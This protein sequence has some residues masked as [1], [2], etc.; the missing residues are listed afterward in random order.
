MNPSSTPSIGCAIITHCAKHHLSHC[1]PPLLNSSLKPRVVVV[2][3][4][5]ND[6]TVELAQSMGAET[7]LI[8]RHEFN[9]GIT[10]ERARQYL[11]TDIV[12]MLTPD[13]YLVDK[14]SLEKLITPIANGYA[15]AAYARQLPHIGADFFEAF[16]REYNYPNHSHIRSIENVDRYGVYTFFCSNSCAAYSNRIMDE[17]GGFQRVLLGED[18][19]AIA[20]MLRKGYKI[21]YVAEAQ[22]RHSHRYTLLEEFRRSFDT[23]LARKSYA[24]VLAC[25]SSDSKRGWDYAQVMAKRL[26]K[27]APQKLPYAIGQVFAKWM[28]YQLGKRSIHAPLWWKKKLSTQDFFWASLDKEKKES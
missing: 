19:L 11:G 25:N 3:S 13:A 24:C 15:S 27:E 12:V 28:G 6:G 18:T 22:V 14:Y 20:S 17:I 23:G 8:P 10:R 9:H 26:L 7:L 5:S 1:L 21:A 4:S 16:P 2:N